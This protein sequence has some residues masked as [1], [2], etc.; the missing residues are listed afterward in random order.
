VTFLHGVEPAAHVAH[1]L[2]LDTLSQVIVF[3]DADDDVHH[4]RKAA[5]ADA[6]LAELVVDFSRN[7]QLPG[8]GIEEAVDDGLNV[9]IG[10]DVAVADEHGRCLR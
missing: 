1:R 8:I 10:D 3:G 5:A 9:A 4:I 6:A 7:D 2:L